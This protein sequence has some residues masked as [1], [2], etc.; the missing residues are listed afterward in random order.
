MSRISRRRLLAAGIGGASAAGLSSVTA[1]T[2][3]QYSVEDQVAFGGQTRRLKLT[4]RDRCIA[5]L[6]FATDYPTHFRLKP[7]L[8]PVCTPAG[9]PV[10]DS[11][12]Y[13]FI[14]HQ[15]IMTGHGKCDASAKV[16]TLTGEYYD[17]MTKKLKTSKTVLRIINNDRHVFEMFDKTPEGEEFVSLEVTYSRG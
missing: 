17:P 2:E 5:S 9:V 10:T 7:E 12:Q 14:H 1:A 8:Y 4:N 13:C 11:H 15:S 3:D 16:I 6:I